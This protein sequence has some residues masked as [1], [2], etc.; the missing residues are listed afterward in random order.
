MK[1]K[2]P[3]IV[4][5]CMLL[6][7]FFLFS[8]ISCSRNTTKNINIINSVQ[9]N[10]Y[11]AEKANPIYHSIN[12]NH[13]KKVASSGLL[14]L[15]I[16]EK[17]FA[18]TVKETTTQKIW[19][20][21]PYE[22]T[23]NS[24]IVSIKVNSSN[25]SYY[26]NS[27]DN[28]VAFGSTTYEINDNGIEVYYNFALNSKDANLDYKELSKG[29][30]KISLSISYI[31]T[32]GNFYA[33]IN[34]KDIEISKGYYI[35]DIDLLNY[36]GASYESLVD[37]YF[38][39]PDGS[40]ALMH[41]HKEDANTSNIIL[42]IY[43]SDYG[44]NDMQQNA[45]VIM[46]IFGVKQGEN[47]F[48]AIIE[49]GDALTTVNAYRRNNGEPAR[50]GASFK[51]A[52]SI[53][54]GNQMHI[55]QPY[56]GQ[57]SLC[58]RFVTGKSANY[59]G[60]ATAARE[61]F[62]RA[63]TLST[64]KVEA[65]GEMPFNLTLYGAVNKN[66]G[67]TARLTKLDQ[68]QD[69]ISIL[70]ARGIDNI[71]LRYKALLSGGIA[72]K[73][74]ANADILRVLGGKKALNELY[75]FM[76]RQK[77]ELYLD[78]NLLT[79]G[80]IRG[81]IGSQSAKRING[82]NISFR[83]ENLLYPYVGAENFYTEALSLDKL[84]EKVIALLTNAR[85]YSI[86]GF[87]INDA[88]YFLYSDF[89][90]YMNRQKA[91]ELIA[92]QTASLSTEKKL[93]V[94]TGNFYTL[95]NADVIV[96]MPF[97]THYPANEAYQPI[98]FAQIILHGIVEYSGKAINTH[99]ESKINMLKYIEYGAVPSYEWVFDNNSTYYYNNKLNQALEFYELSEE[100]LGDL[101]DARITSNYSVEFN[102]R[103]TQYDTGAI[104]YVNYN[105][106]PVN[107]NDIIIEPMSCIR[108]N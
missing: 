13:L 69:L 76:S 17:N 98:P 75:S 61:Q 93:M 29:A 38:M 53:S 40:G 27:Q 95:K 36:F 103:C 28:S 9:G 100:I 54:T 51:I 3:A 12:P 68:A 45:N 102:V 11:T 55:S 7:S 96:N 63:G 56:T 108:V 58:Y 91:K 79:A 81:F 104:I 72:Q 34:C 4:F 50:V 67:F 83:I 65:V 32:D 105:N 101:R 1:S 73:D 80:G 52:P 99:G 42:P 21:M 23:Q 14:E 25:G 59:S 18:I 43:G 10:V 88:G 92:K 16:D 33:K 57:I 78:I 8:S 46:P 6:A 5:F 107:I 49:Y 64:R 19:L 85:K 24:S 84:E 2:K 70:K 90:T 37:D 44:T 74:I 47:A 35:E 48:A 97:S 30:L 86:G 31:L 77:L 71:N 87:C 60:M 82:N 22:N 106:Y 62:I 15:Y 66:N 26:L 20:S 39:L 41:L 89:S 94:D